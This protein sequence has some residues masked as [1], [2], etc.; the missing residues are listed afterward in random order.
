MAGEV[1]KFAANNDSA[2]VRPVII[3]LRGEPMDDY[4]SQIPNG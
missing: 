2:A 4:A 3:A 1:L